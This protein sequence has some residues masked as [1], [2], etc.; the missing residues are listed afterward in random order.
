MRLFGDTYSGP[1]RSRCNDLK[2]RIFSIALRSYED[3]RVFLTCITA[4]T[5]STGISGGSPESFG[6]NLPDQ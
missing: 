1:T 4:Y 6:V 3:E 2:D 5:D